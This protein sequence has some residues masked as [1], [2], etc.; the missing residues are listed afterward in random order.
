MS[1]L[2]SHQDSGP[3]E[4]EVPIAATSRRRGVV[5]VV[6]VVALVVLFAVLHLTG[7]VGGEGHG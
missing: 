5:I 7:V 6:A 4:T 1:E 3:D 2:P